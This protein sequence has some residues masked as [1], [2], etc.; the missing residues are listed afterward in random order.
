LAAVL[1]LA[2]MGT[3]SGVVIRGNADPL[4]GNGGVLN[5]IYW[6]SQ[7]EFDVDASCI[8]GTG[9]G[10]CAATNMSVIGT[11]GPNVSTTTVNLTFSNEPVSVNLTWVNGIV[12][13]INTSP[14][15]P[16]Q[17][18]SYSG[19]VAGFAWIDW[20]I[21]GDGTLAEL[22]IQNCLT[23]V[24]TTQIPS[25]SLSS[26]QDDCGPVAECLPSLEL[27]QN[28]VATRITITQIPEPGIL[29]LLVVGLS[30]LMFARQRA[31]IR[32]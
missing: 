15:G 29:L 18:F 1:L 21:G 26:Y 22:L 24:S 31:N 14:I 2:G 30:A 10:S 20:G 28:S 19:S 6:T 8:A 4:F 23:E 17:F 9:S 32:R 13:G 12:T 11:L 27:A 7:I 3:A 5:N 25:F 16:S